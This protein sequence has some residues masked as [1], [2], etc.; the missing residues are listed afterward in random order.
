MNSEA[1]APLDLGSSFERD[2]TA[3]RTE[4]KFRI[5]TARTRELSRRLSALLEPHRFTGDGAN[6]LPEAMHYTTTIYF[7]TP[8]RRLWQAA[9]VAPSESVKVRAREYYDLH[10]ALAEL[11]TNPEQLVRAQPWLWFELKRREQDRTFK[12][13]FRL[14]KQD[15]PRFLLGQGSADDRVDPARIDARAFLASLGEPV[16]ASTLVQYQRLAYH[17]AASQL[18]ITLDQDIR[19]Y[20][21]PAGLWRKPRALVRGSFGEPRGVEAFALL[22]VKRRGALPTWL[23]ELL[24]SVDALD[25]HFSKFVRAGQVVHGAP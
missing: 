9:R 16:H 15:V 5:P 21:A 25:S 12:Q 3:S 4:D 17:D 18:R 13:R 1:G 2:V 14:L 19:Y 20:A 24:A 8:S 7:D 22:E 23:S 10:P 11:A 6:R